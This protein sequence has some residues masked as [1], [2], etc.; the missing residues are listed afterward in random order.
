MLRGETTVALVLRTDD[1]GAIDFHLASILGCRVNT[2]WSK[3]TY[4][5]ADSQLTQA[6]MLDL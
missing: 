6:G 3:C 2:G 1:L 5:R 4:I